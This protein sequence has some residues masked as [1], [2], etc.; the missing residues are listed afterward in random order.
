M[1]QEGCIEGSQGGCQIVLA[2]NTITFG[3]FISGKI[4]KDLL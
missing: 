2:E 3:Q 4:L 1:M